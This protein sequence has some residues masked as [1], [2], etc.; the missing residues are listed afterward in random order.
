M[1]RSIAFS[2]LFS[3]VSSGWAQTITGSITGTIADPAGAVI[4]EATVQA[5]NV[6]TNITTQAKTSSAGVYNL[7]FLPVGTYTISAQATGFKM[8]P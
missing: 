8:A 5:K 6:N 4:P 2:L 3:A 1:S 7:L